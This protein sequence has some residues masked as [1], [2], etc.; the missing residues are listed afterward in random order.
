[1]QQACEFQWK[2]F[3]CHG[4]RDPDLAQLNRRVNFQQTSPKIIDPCS[5][6]FACMRD[7]PCLYIFFRD[8][9][10]MENFPSEIR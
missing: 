1:M 9:C 2:I 3:H 10:L 6:T 7:R 4:G 5:S 8:V